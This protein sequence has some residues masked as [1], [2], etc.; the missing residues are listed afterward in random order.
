MEGLSELA[1][2]YGCNYL[3]YVAS[4]DVDT[5]SKLQSTGYE[6]LE[7]TNGYLI[8]RLGEM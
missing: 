1:R 4:L 5:R 2:Q 6:L 8:F 3:V 7:E